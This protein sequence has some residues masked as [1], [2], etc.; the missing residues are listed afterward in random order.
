VEVQA[1]TGPNVSTAASRGGNISSISN[2]KE[3]P[4]DVRQSLRSELE[5]SRIAFHQLLDA[6]TDEDWRNRSKNAGWTN[7]EILF[8]MTLGFIVVSRVVPIV[9]REATL[10]K[11]YSLQFAHTLDFITPLFNW[12]N[13]FAARMGGKIYTRR[14]IGHKYDRVHAAVLRA[15]HGVKNDELVLGIHLPSRWD[16]SLKIT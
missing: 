9:R 14:R 10:P 16:P 15:L 7:G 13:A 1:P 6:L 12:I 5:S 2:L 8:H 4:D 11:R 3:D